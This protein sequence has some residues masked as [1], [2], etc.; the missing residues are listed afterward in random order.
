MVTAPA[1][2]L[3]PLQSKIGPTLKK[4][5]TKGAFSSLGY[6]TGN[7]FKIQIDNSDIESIEIVIKKT[8]GRNV[9]ISSLNK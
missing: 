9:D 2:F 7:M 6:P 8:M 3:H 1:V 5:N 4:L